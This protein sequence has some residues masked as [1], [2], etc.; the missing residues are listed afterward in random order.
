MTS[1][2]KPIKSHSNFLLHISL[3]IIINE[4]VAWFASFM[5]VDEEKT[6]ALSKEQFLNCQ[7]TSDGRR[8]E[9]KRN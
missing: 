2:N 5:R 1:C 6:T 4:L 8:V 7:N 3:L 9:V